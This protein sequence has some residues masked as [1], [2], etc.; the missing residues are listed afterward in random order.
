MVLCDA[1]VCIG[2]VLYSF[3]VGRSETSFG[4]TILKI[5]K[6]MRKG[7]RMAFGSKD[8]AEEISARLQAP[9]AALLLWRWKAG[10]LQGGDG[11]RHLRPLP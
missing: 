10:D 8:K 4:G 2:L 7:I 5:V 3:Q 9:F 1:A 11:R 6:A